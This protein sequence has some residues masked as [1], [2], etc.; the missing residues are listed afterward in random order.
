MTNNK[1]DQ[2]ERRSLAGSTNTTTYHSR[3]MVDFE[4]ESTA[5]RFGKPSVV[6]GSQPG[7]HYPA[8]A[9]WTR[10][11]AGVEPPLN[12]DINAQ[13]PVGEL[14]ELA[15]PA[16]SDIGSHL[17]DVV[18]TT[19]P[20]IPAKA[21]SSAPMAE[22][23]VP[24]LPLLSDDVAI[25]TAKATSSPP[26]PASVSSLPS[27]GNDVASLAAGRSWVHVQPSPNPVMPPSRK[28]LLIKRR[29]IAA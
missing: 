10:D 3:A 14:H 4:L 24:P 19:G 28:P 26:V 16:G 27:V 11:G 15:G 12:F 5:G 7:V 29:K 6:S 13:E 1:S 22:V 8:A 20:A 18:E 21:T 9:A 2:A 23:P 25:P 17:P